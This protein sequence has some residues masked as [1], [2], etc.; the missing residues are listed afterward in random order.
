LTIFTALAATE[1]PT[2]TNKKTAT[3]LVSYNHA[4][5]ATS[6]RTI[7]KLKTIDTITITIIIIT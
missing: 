7:T 5:L 1:F 6:K 3:N 2:D 4:S